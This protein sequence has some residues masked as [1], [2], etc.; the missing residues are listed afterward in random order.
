MLKA[1]KNLILGI[2]IAV[3]LVLLT[4]CGTTKEI[5]Y[6]SVICEQDIPDFPELYFYS[7]SEDG[8]FVTVDSL[9][10][11]NVA[12]YKIKME[13]LKSILRRIEEMDRKNK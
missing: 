8:T 11:Q 1:R 13:E 4:S 12:K 10:F 9:W 6:R 2:I 7:E 3:I 5:E